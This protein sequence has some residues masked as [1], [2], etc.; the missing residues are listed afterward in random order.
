MKLPVEILDVIVSNNSDSFKTLLSWA[1]ISPYYRDAISQEVYIVSVYDG[2][3]SAFWCPLNYDIL[4]TT[5]NHIS[6]S[7]AAPNFEFMANN[8]KSQNNILI[9]IHSSGGFSKSLRLI[10]SQIARLC[11]PGANVCV[12]YENSTNFL[13]KLYFQEFERLSTRLNLSELHIFGSQETYVNSGLF[14]LTTLFQTTYLDSILNI[15]SI[16][17]TDS[18]HCIIAPVIENIKSISI[19]PNVTDIVTPLFSCPSINNLGSLNFPSSCNSEG[20]FIIPSCNNIS[21]IN[22]HSGVKYSPINGVLVRN[23]LILSE[24]MLEYDPTFRYL[25]FPN[26]RELELDVGTTPNQTVRFQQCE[27]QNLQ[28]LNVDSSI[29]PWR[30]LIMAGSHINTLKLKLYSFD[31]IKWLNECPFRI[32]NIEILPSK[33]S[34]IPNILFPKTCSFLET[35]NNITVNA[36][37]LL[38][39]N[40]LQ[41]IFLDDI[42][43]NQTLGLTIHQK[44]ISTAIKQNPNYSS[45]YEL[46]V[47]DSSDATFSI[48]YIHHL[49][50]SLIPEQIPASPEEDMLAQQ[51]QLQEN[52][53]ELYHFHNCTLGVQAKFTS[54]T[55]EIED[56]SR[57]GS[58]FSVNSTFS[59]GFDGRRRSTLSSL[60]LLSEQAST[61][62]ASLYHKVMTIDFVESLPDI[63]CVDMNV[64]DMVRFEVKNVQPAVLHLIQISLTLP[65]ICPSLDI[66]QNTIII[67]ASKALEYPINSKFPNIIVERLQLLINIKENKNIHVS[68]PG[69]FMNSLQDKITNLLGD[70]SLVDCD[71]IP[72]NRR[73]I[74]L[75]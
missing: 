12:I 23:K 13:S 51:K 21:L 30:D 17:I 65:D 33:N 64:L 9:A 24:G 45:I 40:I 62:Y 6:V 37:S 18:T 41:N 55:S 36:D 58:N 47:T 20:Q 34:N 69:A 26:L 31:Q 22:Y 42:C 68:L 39:Y 35:F 67:E 48:P 3:N 43:I 57:R 44:E 7:T 66:L 1:R 11:H 56:T 5:N 72:N 19:K 15:N 53:P 14:D 27:F 60:P 71:I 74:C 38:H 63:L 25:N 4:C 52:I 2:F 54:P 49:K 46:S 32:D 59:N 61:D 10:L 8:I 75:I 50:I 70:I 29:V 73:S 16:L 28:I